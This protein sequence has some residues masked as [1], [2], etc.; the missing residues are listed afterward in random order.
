MLLLT[1]ADRLCRVVRANYS[2]GRILGFL[3]RSRYIFLQVAPELYS[4]RLSGP[5]SRPITSQKISILERVMLVLNC[6]GREYVGLV[7]S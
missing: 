1:F 3:D 7:M 5:C 2:L 6:K 4:T